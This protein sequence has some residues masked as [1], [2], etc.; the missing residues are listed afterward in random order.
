MYSTKRVMLAVATASLCQGIDIVGDKDTTW[1]AD[2][3]CRIYSENEFK[4][5]SADFCTDAGDGYDGVYNLKEYNGGAW[6]KEMM[7]WK[8]GRNTAAEFCA[9]PNGNLCEKRSHG[10]SA[11]GGA[12]SQDTGLNRKL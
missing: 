6:K 5:N 1:P 2:T 3:C 4:G 7:S 11:G 12:E 10:E 9:N 8:C